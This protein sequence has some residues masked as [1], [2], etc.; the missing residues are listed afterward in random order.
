MEHTENTI[1]TMSM[2]IT[3]L[4]LTIG[5]LI[6]FT[7][8]VLKGAFAEIKN[9]LYLVK[10]ILRPC[11]QREFVYSIELQRAVIN[12]ILHGFPLGVI[13]FSKNSDGTFE[14]MD[15]QQRIISIMHFKRGDFSITWDGET[16]YWHNLPA[17]LKAKIEN[18][19]LIAFLCD[20]NESDK[21][22]WFVI[23]NKQGAVLNAQEMLNAIHH[24][25]FIS[26]AREYFS[27]PLC[28]AIKI[29]QINGKPLITGTPIRQDILA[30]VLS[31]KADDEHC[32]VEELVSKHQHDENADWLWEY[33]AKVIEWVKTKFNQYRKE[34][35]SVKWGLLYN[36]Y[37]G[38]SRLASELEAEVSELM[39]NDEVTKKSGVY[40]YVFSRDERCL[41]LRKFSDTQ[42]RTAYEKQGGRCAHC[43]EAFA[44]EDMHGDHKVSFAAGGKTTLENLQMLCA[45]CNNAKNAKSDK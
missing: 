15:G 37:K 12:S 18:Y 20:G 3:S 13:Y 36:R 38:D 25:T 1:S 30:L 35:A 16:Y 42:K 44:Y 5:S 7:D 40:E 24:G 41:S 10:L 9:E 19:Q 28:R 45:K 23:V 17:E 4:F 8:D 6:G 22:K 11:Y 29:A 39:A 43:G 14:T 33:Y 2:Q 34:M 21:L 31:W 27:K 26:S 32:T